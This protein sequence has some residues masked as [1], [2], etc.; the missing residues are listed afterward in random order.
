MKHT[1]IRTFVLI[2]LGLGSLAG[3]RA[4][5]ATDANVP[6]WGSLGGGPQRTGLSS[7]EGPASLQVQRTFATKAPVQAG[8]A[9]DSQGRVYLA[10]ANGILY[11]LKADGHVDWTYDAN[12]A[13]R[14]A[15]TLAPDGTV[16]I[17][18]ESGVLHALYASGAL[19]WKYQTGGAIGG[20]VAAGAKDLLVF[21]SNDGCVYAL[22]RA[23]R[24]VWK[25]PFS[26]TG[27]T[28]AALFASPALAQDGTVYIGTAQ[29]P[30]LYALN[31]GD[32]TVK[33]MCK[34]PH[35]TGLVVSPV[36]GSGGAI[37]QMLQRDDHLY[38]VNQQD[39]SILWATDLTDANQTWYRPDFV[40]APRVTWP[41]ND[42]GGWSE[43]VLGP[44]GTIYVSLDDPYLRAVNPDGTV[45]WGVRL[46]DFG[47]FTL[48]VDEG[49][50]VYAASESGR[51]YI[52]NT[53]GQIIGQATV[54]Q[55]AGYPVIGPGQKLVVSDPTDHGLSTSETNRVL[56][57]GA[58]ANTP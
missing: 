57:L 54:D 8:V 13:V 26:A 27:S 48:T 19:K 35:G 53:V 1:R 56:I 58:V 21:G 15:P 37:Y 42:A 25:H 30:N 22:D 38:A 9:L 46:G 20:S 2:S 24:L 14:S 36:V 11:C 6:L 16:V 31:P 4:P 12:S 33:W 44:D 23:G 39:G 18:C 40:E 43:P 45:K 52:V 47:T 32:G 10:D 41:T 3:V 49:G 17:G 34:F 5:A 50:R 55:W 29:D 51:L 28:P 7:L